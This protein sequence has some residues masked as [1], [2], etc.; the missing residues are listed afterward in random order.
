MERS[1]SRVQVSMNN[2]IQDKTH[3]KYHST[4]AVC[5]IIWRNIEINQLIL[6][7]NNNGVWG[8][9]LNIQNE[10][11][12]DLTHTHN[13]IALSVYLHARILRINK[14]C[15]H[16]RASG[17]A[18]RR[19]WKV[20]RK[21]INFAKFINTVPQK[22]P[23]LPLFA[24]SRLPP[25]SHSNV[26]LVSLLLRHR[27]KKK[28]L[29]AYLCGVPTLTWRIANLLHFRPFWGA[30]KSRNVEHHHQHNK[31]AHTDT[32]SERKVLTSFHFLHLTLA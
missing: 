4:S 25:S 32:H 16:G 10:M 14:S 18:V 12:N 15:R 11:F 19:K 22:I 30:D 27:E 21:S 20:N 26:R 28:W 29:K 3:M 17:A 23:F 24:R 13:N 5:A 6:R 8:F 7:M 9:S 1:T 2:I 31:H